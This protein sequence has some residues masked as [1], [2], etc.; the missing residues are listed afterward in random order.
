[1]NYHKTHRII[2]APIYALVI[3]LR[4]WWFGC[5]P[6]Q[7]DDEEYLAYIDTTRCKH[8]DD[9]IQYCDL[10][11]DT[12]H[13]R[14]KAWCNYWFFRKWLPEKCSKCGRRWRECDF[15]EDHIPF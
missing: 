12:Q 4:C 1:M 11:G 8:C 3:R 2:V 10:V 13:N 6:W 9:E 14:F 7:V 15:D 5:E